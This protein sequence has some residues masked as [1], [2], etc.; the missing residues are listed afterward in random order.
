MEK[1]E[2]GREKVEVDTLGGRSE[3]MCGQG[4]DEGVSRVK[5]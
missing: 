3:E 5:E 4:M 2:K 1:T